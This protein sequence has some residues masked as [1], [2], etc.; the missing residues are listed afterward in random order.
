[1]GFVNWIGER[2]ETG[3]GIAFGGILGFNKGDKEIITA[4]DYRL[5]KQPAQLK[6][7]NGQHDDN[8]HHVE[9]AD[10]GAEQPSC[11]RGGPAVDI[12]QDRPGEAAADRSIG[13]E[14]VDERARGC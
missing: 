4:R 9:R 6:F 7:K 5:G 12:G 2:I 8:Q 1:M 11:C 10:E 3:V 13:H 14:L